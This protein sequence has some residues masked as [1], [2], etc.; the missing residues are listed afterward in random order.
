VVIIHQS[1][2]GLH[3]VLSYPRF[4]AGVTNPGLPLVAKVQKNYT[5]I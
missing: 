3:R 5:G 1:D 4:K 2:A